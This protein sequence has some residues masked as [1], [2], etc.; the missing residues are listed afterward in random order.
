MGRVAL[1]LSDIAKSH[2]DPSVVSELDLE[3]F[4]GEFF[5]LI[6]LLFAGQRSK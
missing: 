5:V 2:G 4:E 6:A 1:A 3:I